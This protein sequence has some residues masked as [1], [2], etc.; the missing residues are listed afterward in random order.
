[1]PWSESDRLPLRSPRAPPKPAAAPIPSVRRLL[2][3]ARQSTAGALDRWFSA[4]DDASGELLWRQRLSDVP[5]SAPISFAAHGR[6]YIAMVVGFG[7]PQA[8]TFPN[9]VPEISLP[10]A[11][12]SSIWVFELP[13][14]QTAPVP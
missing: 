8:I 2:I 12:S 5:S 3:F 4:Y 10:P 9:L 6:Q 7:S 13:T 14:A 1:M 11:R